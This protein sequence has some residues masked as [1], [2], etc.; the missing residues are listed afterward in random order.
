MTILYRV[1][2]KY[3]VLREIKFANIILQQFFSKTIQ[4]HSFNIKLLNIVNFLNSFNV[5]ENIFYVI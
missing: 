3:L 5:S 2:K 4:S 1:L